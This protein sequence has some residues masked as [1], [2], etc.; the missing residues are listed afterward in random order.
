MWWFFIAIHY[1]PSSP[2][3]MFFCVAIS[4]PTLSPPW[5]GPPCDLLTQSPH[6]RS[7]IIIRSVKSVPKTITHHQIRTKQ[8]QNDYP[9]S[10]PPPWLH[11]YPKSY[12]QPSLYHRKCRVRKTLTIDSKSQ[13]LFEFEIGVLIWDCESGF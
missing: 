6:H 11:P 3:L 5:H 4:L 7:I 2:P 9:A 8:H 1:Q 10:Q 12:A 13:F